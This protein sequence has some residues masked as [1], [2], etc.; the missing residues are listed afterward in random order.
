MNVPV[1]FVV[2]VSLLAACENVSQQKPAASPDAGGPS[3]QC[4]EGKQGPQGEVGKTGSQGPAGKAGD[5]GKDGVKGDKG[6][7]GV[8]GPQGPQGVAGV[9]G[10]MGDT[11]AQGLPGSDG[12]SCVAQSVTEGVLLV[13][14]NEKI[15]VKHGDVGPQGIAGVQG[16]AGEKGADGPQGSVG[17]TGPSGPQGVKGDQGF[18]G[19]V[20][21]DGIAGSKGEKGDPGPQGV[22]GKDYI[23]SCPAGSIPVVLDGILMYCYA[24]QPATYTWTQCLK[25]CAVQK[26][27]IA[28]IEGIVLACMA[29]PA[30]FNNTQH[31]GYYIKATYSFETLWPHSKSK[32]QEFCDVANKPKFV[33]IMGYPEDFVDQTGCFGNLQKQWDG[34]INAGCICG[35]QPF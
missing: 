3:C 10:P 15:L 17:P 33:E 18:Q 29:N 21:K 12:T 32:M 30:M 22:L 11:G 4:T 13:C 23:A 8:V 2:A 35:H 20:G 34:P 19:L 16:L 26:M 1:S 31:D 14:G 28:H 5:S 6:D 27:G 7:A 9:Q 25:T 24:I